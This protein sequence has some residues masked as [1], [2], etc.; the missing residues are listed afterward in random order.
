MQTL[1]KVVFADSPACLASSRRAFS[2]VLRTAL[3]L[4]AC[5][6]FA[7]EGSAQQPGPFGPQPPP[8]GAPGAQPP[9]GGQ[10][11]PFGP[12]P[13][14]GGQPGPFGPQPGGPPPGGAPP[15]GPPGGQP[16]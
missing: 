2:L 8:G 12:Q 6:L 10:P 11:G 16:G 13:P 9:P 15:G 14:P 1:G 4:L 7:A 5:V 3:P